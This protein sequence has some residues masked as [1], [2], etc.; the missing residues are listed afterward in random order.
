MSSNAKLNRSLVKQY[1]KWMVAMHY[2]TVTKI[3]YLKA[4]NSYLTFLGDRSLVRVT[5]T[6]IRLF[7]ADASENGATLSTVYRNLGVL[8][9][10][11]DFL[12][13]GGVV[14]YVAPR[15]VRLRVPWR[16]GLRV[17]NQEQVRRIIS[18]ARSLRE[19]A[20]I[21]FLYSSGC[22]L[23]EAIHLKIQD[24]DFRAR[25][26]R[27]RGKLGKVRLVLIAESAAS[28]LLAYI[29]KRT[30]GY[31]FETDY[32]APTGHFSVHEGRWKSRWKEQRK[33]E[34]ARVY[35]TKVLGSF[36]QL[37]YS[38]AKRRHEALIA[39][40]ALTPV[41][42]S[43]LSKMA[44]QALVASVGRRAGLKNITPHVFR[45]TFATHLHENG[46]SLEVIRA[47]LG[48]VWIQTT[49]RYAKIGPDGLMKSFERC[50]P[51]GNRHES[52]N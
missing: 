36:R 32:P 26:A 17:L 14:D 47:L 44:V 39:S 37:S 42:R 7:I 30:N 16:N 40:L 2:A 11:Y 8:R 24:I 35:R 29:G 1:Q 12:N 45:R 48:H 3:V 41:R 49:V 46:A 19:R 31:V 38:E 33:G 23:S 50:H 25:Q 52:Q 27:V 21:E 13:L 51:L 20:V 28:A 18:A 4:L 43:P 22:R 34:A 5:H 15:F 6:D 9:Q 10:F